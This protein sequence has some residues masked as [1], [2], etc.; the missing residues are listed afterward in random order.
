MIPNANVVHAFACGQPAHAGNLWT[1]GRSLYS[2][3]MKIAGRT[4]AGVVVGDFTSTGG[5]F[6]SMTTSRHVNIAK[7][8]ADTVMLPE[9]FT[10]TFVEMPL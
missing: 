3:K 5:G 4:L 6:I 9:T 1:D 8:V 2:Y 10:A 7:R